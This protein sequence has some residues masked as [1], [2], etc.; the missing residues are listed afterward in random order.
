MAAAQKTEME[1]LAAR[2]AGP[3]RSFFA[4]RIAGSSD[5]EDLVQDVFVRLARH[6]RLHEIEHL[7][8]Y[9]FQIARNVLRDRQ[10]RLAVRAIECRE[11][12]DHVVDD[13]A[14]SP[15]RVLIGRDALER[16]VAALQELPVKTR[17]I[18]TLYHF[19]GISQVDIS[20]RLLISL[21]TVEKHMA[22]ANAHLLRRT[23]A[24][25]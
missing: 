20:R 7:E 1:Q 15:E 10:R 22:R 18:F 14:I 16:L 3:L 2:Y 21:S 19:E 11:V 9:V 5:A 6:G 8:G 17:R 4:R 24:T 13:M 23:G 25:S 12:A